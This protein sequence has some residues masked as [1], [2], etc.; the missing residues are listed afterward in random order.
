MTLTGPVTAEL[1]QLAGQ[2]IQVRG[3]TT[4]STIDVYGYAFA[5][6]VTE[7]H[8]IGIVEQRGADLWL[9]GED[10]IRLIDP[11]PSLAAEL[12]ALVWVTG[13]RTDTDVTPH[14]FGVIRE[15]QP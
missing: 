6:S 10:A 2:D 5:P 14:L 4:G 3:V 15:A 7:P 12:G 9:L 11:P 13:P 1:M 8:W